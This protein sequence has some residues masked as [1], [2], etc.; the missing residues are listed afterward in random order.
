MD[1]LVRVGVTYAKVKVRDLN[2]RHG[3]GCG[4]GDEDVQG[5]CVSKASRRS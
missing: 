2:I 3:C 1:D 5:P 4:V